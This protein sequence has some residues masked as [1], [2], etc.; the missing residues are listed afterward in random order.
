MLKKYLGKVL[1]VKVFMFLRLKLIFKV[2]KKASFIF[3]R[4]LHKPQ[5]KNFNV[6][7]FSLITFSRTNTLILSKLFTILNFKMKN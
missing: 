5:I 4:F 6:F 2:L 3:H 7:F 1:S